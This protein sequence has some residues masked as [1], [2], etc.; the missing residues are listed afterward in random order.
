[1]ICCS[2]T[3]LQAACVCQFGWTCCLLS[4]DP[5]V[6]CLLVASFGTG[7]AYGEYKCYRRIEIVVA[8]SA[9]VSLH[10]KQTSAL[11]EVQCCLTPRHPC[12]PTTM[13]TQLLA[14]NHR[15]VVQ[16]ADLW[17][18]FGGGLG[19]HSSPCALGWAWQS[20]AVH[21]PPGEHRQ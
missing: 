10:C 5:A 16:Q 6:P 3:C 1:M 20:C 2:V 8:C 12:H 7:L 13:C 14:S 11:V 18:A 4:T 19:C 21:T 9:G 17:C 15:L